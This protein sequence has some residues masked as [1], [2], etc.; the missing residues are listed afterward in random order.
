MVVGRINWALSYKEK[1]GRF[2]ETGKGLNESRDSFSPSRE[3][4]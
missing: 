3:R 1:Y 2:A 4:Y